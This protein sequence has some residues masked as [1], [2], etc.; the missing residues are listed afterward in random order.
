M[1]RIK[2]NADGIFSDEFNQNLWIYTADCMPILFAD[3]RSRFVAALHCGRKGLEKGIIKKLV[4]LFDA[5]GSSRSDLIVAIGPSISKKNYFVD[6]K[7]FEEF[8][9]NYHNEG[10]TSFAKNIE[11]KLYLTELNKSFNQEKIQIDLKNYAYNQ[12]L[13]ENIPN[14]NIEI[15]SLCTY[16]SSNEFNSWRKTRTHS[17]QWNFICP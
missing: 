1:Q 7:T 17:R 15:S 4:K 16:E 10:S 8:Y 9:V 14:T 6:K 3:K 13:I 2:V 12:I 5:V 11:R